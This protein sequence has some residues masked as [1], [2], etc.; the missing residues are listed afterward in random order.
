MPQVGQSDNIWLTPEQVANL[1]QVSTKTVGRWARERRIK[2]VR[3]P[4]GHR[5]YRQ[6]DVLKLFVESQGME[7]EGNAQEG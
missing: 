3:T 2:S 6:S 1:F 7:E 4:G 5:R